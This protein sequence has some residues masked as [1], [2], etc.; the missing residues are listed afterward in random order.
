MWSAHCFA[1]LA[2]P[3][4][5]TAAAKFEALEGAG[6]TVTRSPAQLGTT[7]HKVMTERGLL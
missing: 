6:V 5:G 2:W 7:M 1:F 3:R 4:Q